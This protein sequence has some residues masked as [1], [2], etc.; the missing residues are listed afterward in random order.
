[1]SARTLGTFLLKYQKSTTWLGHTTFVVQ[2]SQD[3][4]SVQVKVTK[5]FLPLRW[6]G[7]S[8]VLK[9]RGLWTQT[10]SVTVPILK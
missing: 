2:T 4:E 6:L 5:Y 1:M 10:I 3:Y 7:H 8:P 9:G